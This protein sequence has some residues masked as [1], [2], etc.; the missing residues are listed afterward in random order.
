MDINYSKAFYNVTDSSIVQN[1]QLNLALKSADPKV[2][3]HYTTNGS[4]A[5]AQSPIYTAPLELGKTPMTVSALPVTPDGKVLCDPYQQSFIANKAAGQKITLSNQPGEKY[6]GKGNTT[7]VDCIVGR[8][9]LMGSEWL[10]FAGDDVDI[11]LEFD[12]PKP[13]SKITVGS[14]N[15]PGQW[16]Y[17][18]QSVECWVSEDGVNF[19]SIGK[20]QYDDILQANCKA[21][22]ETPIRTVKKIKAVVKNF[23]VI[24][25]GE[26]GGGNRAWLFLD[27]I[28]VE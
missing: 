19:Q 17:A 24:P 13:V 26:Q 16:I 11:T 27:E 1:G 20:K 15:H 22:L 14:T 4:K 2:A 25:E 3:I 5:T 18:P 8:Y 9:P 12:Q 10:G 21:V 7:L 6:R 28:I 23:G